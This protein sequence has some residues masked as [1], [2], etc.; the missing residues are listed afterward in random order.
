MPDPDAVGQDPIGILDELNE[1][2]LYPADYF[3]PIELS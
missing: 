2:Y 3:I 1:D